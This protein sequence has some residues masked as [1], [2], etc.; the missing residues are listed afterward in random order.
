MSPEVR[1]V[2]FV[3][4]GMGSQWPHMGRDLMKVDFFRE[5]IVSCHTVLSPFGVDL[6]DLLANSKE[7]TFDSIDNSFV[8]ILAIQVIF[9]ISDSRKNCPYFDF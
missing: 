4:T 1:P 3:F 9:Y 5:S 8:G 2:W 6:L 7:D